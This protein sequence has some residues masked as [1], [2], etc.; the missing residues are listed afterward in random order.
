[1]TLYVIDDKQKVG[2]RIHEGK[3]NRIVFLPEGWEGEE[4]VRVYPS[5]VVYKVKGKGVNLKVK[6]IKDKKY[7]DLPKAF[8]GKNHVLLVRLKLV[9]VNGGKKIL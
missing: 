4:L 6:V 9:D 5:E 2:K 7:V 1:M 8:S 3:N